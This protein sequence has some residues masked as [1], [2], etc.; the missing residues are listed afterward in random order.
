MGAFCLMLL[1]PS[2]WLPAD[3]QPP[4]PLV[5]RCRHRHNPPR[6]PG[7]SSNPTAGLDAWKDCSCSLA[8]RC[9][10]ATSATFDEGLLERLEAQRTLLDLGR[11]DRQRRGDFLD[12]GVLMDEGQMMLQIRRG[13]ERGA[14]R[15]HEANWRN[16]KH[17]DTVQFSR[18]R[19]VC[20]RACRSVPRPCIAAPAGVHRSPNELHLAL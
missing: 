16:S 3:R 5:M 19:G 14:R 20:R 13:F 17:H 18:W 12:C 6:S 10:A 1:W 8:Y 4:D 7:G 15:R 9:R 2:R 11:N